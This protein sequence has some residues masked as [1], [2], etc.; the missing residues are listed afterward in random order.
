MGVGIKSMFYHMCDLRTFH[1][2]RLPF[3]NL[4]ND[5]NNAC[6]SHL[7]VFD[8]SVYITMEFNLKHTVKLGGISAAEVPLLSVPWHLLY[9]AASSRKWESEVGARKNPTPTEYRRE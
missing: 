7:K 5:E 6:S 1:F 9:P 2:S 8:D 3:C 4:W